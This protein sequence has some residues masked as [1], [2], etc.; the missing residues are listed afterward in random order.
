M[1]ISPGQYSS[2]I[3]GKMMHSNIICRYSIR[4]PFPSHRVHAVIAIVAVLH[5]YKVAGIHVAGIEREP[6]V[7][8]FEETF[9]IT[10]KN[11]FHA[12]VKTNERTDYCTILGC[13]CMERFDSF[14]LASDDEYTSLYFRNFWHMG[15]RCAVTTHAHSITVRLFTRRPDRSLFQAEI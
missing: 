9:W 5:G 1:I 8:V 10:Q 11:E 2:Q 3:A 14:V 13:G 7:H 4:R 15:L 6:A 12:R